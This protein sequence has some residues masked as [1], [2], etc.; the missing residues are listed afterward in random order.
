ML[1]QLGGARFFN[2]IKYYNK[3]GYLRNIYLKV[4]KYYLKR[5]KWTS[6]TEQGG[7]KDRCSFSKVAT[8]PS[9]LG[10]QWEW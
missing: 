9:N 2:L 4:Y 10:V 7:T 1:R 8:N 6:R 5:F 3:T